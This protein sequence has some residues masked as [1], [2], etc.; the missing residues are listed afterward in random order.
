MSKSE[1]EQILQAAFDS[2]T[3]FINFMPHYSYALL[4]KGTDWQEVSYDFEDH[5]LLDN[6]EIT[7]TAAFQNFCE[8]IEKAMSS[9][10]AVFYL[11]RW[12]EFKGTLSGDD[13]IKLKAM[14]TELTS[15]SSH[16]GDD[17]PI[18]LTKAD[19]PTLLAKL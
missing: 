6:Q 12:L 18:I 4:P 9:E 1:Y 7:S 13:G 17:I 11:N 16:Y 10:I 8:E 3:P 2:G 5:E 14:I 15:N 19:I